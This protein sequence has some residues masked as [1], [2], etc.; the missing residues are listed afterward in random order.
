MKKT[1]LTILAISLATILTGC[2]TV[3]TH[4][5]GRRIQSDSVMQIKPGVTTKDSAVD[6]FGNPTEITHADGVDTFIYKYEEEKTPIYFGGLVQM[7]SQRRTYSKSL[8]LTI[9]DGIVYSYRFVRDTDV[10]PEDQS[11]LTIKTD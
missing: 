10:E 1:A 7:E 11:P 3:E 6:L 9:K 8:E 2:T 4:S 5:R